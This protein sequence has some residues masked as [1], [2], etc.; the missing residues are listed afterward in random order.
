MAASESGALVFSDETL[1]WSSRVHST[2][3]QPNSAKLIGQRWKFQKDTAKAAQERIIIIL[4]E[5]SSMT[6]SYLVMDMCSRLQAVIFKRIFIKLLHLN[7]SL[8]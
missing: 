6:K 5:F 2:Q 1:D 3:I 4:G 8:W 7:F